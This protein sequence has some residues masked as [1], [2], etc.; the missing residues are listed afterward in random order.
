VQVLTPMGAVAEVGFWRRIGCWLR[1]VRS[2]LSLAWAFGNFFVATGLFSLF[3]TL[4]A[5]ALVLIGVP[6]AQAAGFTAIH[7]D[8]DLAEVQ[9]L[10]ERVTPDAD[11][12]VRISAFTSVLSV[13][14][15]MAVATGT[16]WL[17]RG[18]GWVYG[19]VV[20]AIQVARPQ[21]VAQ[22]FAIVP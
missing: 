16:L 2:W 17:A 18:T 12:L 5:L 19:Q 15:G 20:K 6:M 13:V 14:L 11:G 10:W 22:R 1:D 3:V 8:G 9:F 7:V 4:A 21:A